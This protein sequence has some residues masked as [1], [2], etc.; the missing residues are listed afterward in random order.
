MFSLGD[1]VDLLGGT[2]CATMAV[3]D[4]YFPNVRHGMWVSIQSITVII[5]GGNCSLNSPQWY[6][7]QLAVVWLTVD[8][9]ASGI[10]IPPEISLSCLVYL[11][12]K[13]ILFFDRF[14]VCSYSSLPR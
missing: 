7:Y 14:W 3:T 9:N 12:K 6:M 4:W 2:I 13:E 11:R 10:S 8:V 1:N 5:R